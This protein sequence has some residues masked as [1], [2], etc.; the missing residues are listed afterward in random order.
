LPSST[1]DAQ[2]LPFE[3]LKPE[4]YFTIGTS[5]GY[6]FSTMVENT[7]PSTSQEYCPIEE[8]NVSQ[9]ADRMGFPDPFTFSR[10]FKRVKG[11]SP[12]SLRKRMHRKG[13]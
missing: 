6:F 4:T 5:K 3:T 8:P 1:Q 7:S 12:S 11:E 2:N 9:V 10:F 13:K